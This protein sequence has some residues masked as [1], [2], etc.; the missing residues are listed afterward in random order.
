MSCYNSM[1]EAIISKVYEVVTNDLDIQALFGATEL[2]EVRMR[3]GQ[4]QKDIDFPY[5]VHSFSD[6]GVG[7]SIIN[8]GTYSFDIWDY[9]TSASTIYSI[10]E[11]IISLLDLQNFYIEEVC[12]IRFFYSDSAIIPELTEEEDY[13][14]HLVLNFDIRYDRKKEIENILS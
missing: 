11:R 6:S 1:Y 14:Q 10:R 2:S 13:I 12:A 7:D 8:S 3:Y 9:S 4:A 5:I